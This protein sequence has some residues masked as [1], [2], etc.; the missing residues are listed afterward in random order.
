MHI[1]AFYFMHFYA[2][3]YFIYILCTFY[4]MPVYILF[5]FDLFR[6]LSQELRY[7]TF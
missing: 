3:F 6:F 4:F 7:M 5:T 1:Y 2:R